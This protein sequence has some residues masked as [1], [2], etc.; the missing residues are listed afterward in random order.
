MGKKLFRKKGDPKP[1]DKDPELEKKLFFDSSATLGPTQSP[2]ERKVRKTGGRGRSWTFMKQW[3]RLF[4]DA[5]E[6]DKVIQVFRK[7]RKKPLSKKARE[8]IEEWFGQI[9]SEAVDRVWNQLHLRYP[10][11]EDR[12]LDVELKIWG[13]FHE[14]LDFYEGRGDSKS[15]PHR[16]ETA[17]HLLERTFDGY[18]R[19]AL[20]G[21]PPPEDPWPV[22]PRGNDQGEAI[23]FDPPDGDPSPEEVMLAKER[24]ETLCKA[25]KALPQHYRCAVILIHLKG[26]SYEEAAKQLRVPVGTVKSW[27][28]RGIRKLRQSEELRDLWGLD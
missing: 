22:S 7:A 25:I 3:F 5:E 13:K 20:K 28:Y 26:E 9:V 15:A 14:W 18:V 19:D 21:P 8:E 17:P 1:R 24:W 23:P 12:V 10:Q 2:I 11:S 27:A 4:S 6:T 16:P